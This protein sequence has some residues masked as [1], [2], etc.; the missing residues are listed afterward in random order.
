MV[1]FKAFYEFLFKSFVVERDIQMIGHLENEGHTAALLVKRSWL[2]GL[3]TSLWLI[4]LIAIAGINGYLMLRHFE[5]STFGI[6]LVSLLGFTIVNTVYS[7]IRY[8]FDYKSAYRESS[9][10]YR[11][12]ELRDHLAVESQ[13]FVR[14]FNQL[15]FNFVFFLIIIGTYLFHIFFISQFAT[16]L[17]AGLDIVCIIIQLTVIHR[18][19]RHLIDLEMDFGLVTVGKVL[20]INQ[21]GLYAEINTVEADKIKSIRSSYP[22]PLASLMHFGT[23]K[24]FLG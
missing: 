14:C 18:I 19:I 12:K 10:I 1:N 20:F 16:G 4:P 15:Q 13:S 7:Q 17:W 9:R 5:Y 6:V 23:V 24:I 8:L 11:T 21:H 22:N 3:F 2:Y